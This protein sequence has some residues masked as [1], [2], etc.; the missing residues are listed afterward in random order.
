MTGYW[1]DLPLL[2][3]TRSSFI[4][5]RNLPEFFLA[6]VSAFN[7]A[8]IVAY[9]LCVVM[10]SMVCLKCNKLNWN[11]FVLIVY[12]KREKGCLIR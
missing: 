7:S 12:H 8:Y 10:A 9:F 4:A 1:C 3:K 5:S 11:S 2:L 6:L